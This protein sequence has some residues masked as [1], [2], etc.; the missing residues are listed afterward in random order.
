[1]T[2]ADGYRRRLIH[3]WT[4][5]RARTKERRRHK[6][7]QQWL[8]QLRSAPPEVLIG[9]NFAAFGGVR[10]HIQAIHRYSTCD[11]QVIPS[12]RMLQEVGAY[13]LAN[14]FRDEF[15]A[16]PATGVK[17]AHSHVF[18][19]FIDWCHEHQK[20]G[21]KWIH[22]YHLNYYPEHGDGT[23]PEPWQLEINE[24]LL[25][26]ARDADV[27]LS[28]SKWQ[29]KELEELHGIQSRYLPNGVD[30]L[31][32]DRGRADRFRQLHQLEKFVLYVGRNDPV[33]NPREFVELARRIQGEVFVMIGGDLSVQSLTRPNE[34]VLP[35]NLRILGGVSQMGVQDAIAASSAV[36]VTSKREG[37]PTLVLEAM[38]RETPLVVPD[39]AGCMEAIEHGRYGEIYH[40]GDVDD[41]ERKVLLTLQQG[42]RD[43]A[44]RIRVLA[45]YDW[46]VVA[47]KLDQI[48]RS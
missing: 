48:Y 26:Q 31:L 19:W 39:E 34:P 25:K 46:R 2:K 40:L 36:I 22:T 35:A 23:N 9:A 24:A 20:R 16:F 1:M 29:V 18:P 21:I 41:L 32:C 3:E 28:V 37:L 11:V 38:T 43:R 42:R 8:C 15:L 17:V 4:Q 7:F 14:I 33:K 10:G 12:E 30:V 27:C 5:W 45:E 13:H 47:A 6:A 44:A